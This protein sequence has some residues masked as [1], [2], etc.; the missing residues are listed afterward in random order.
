[1]SVNCRNLAMRLRIMSAG[2]HRRALRR[3][4]VLLQRRCSM[5][6]G[7]DGDR[8]E[9]TASETPSAEPGPGPQEGRS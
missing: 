4:L 9:T 5:Q 7:D 8:Q 6:P 3:E 1:M 2:G